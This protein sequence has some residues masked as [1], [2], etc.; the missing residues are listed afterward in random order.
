MVLLV[1]TPTE[2][3]DAWRAQFRR[4]DPSLEVRVW[5]DTGALDEIDVVFAW[6]TTPGDLTRY[7]NLRAVFSLGA[8][9]DGLLADPE[10][11]R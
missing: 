5:P 11:P 7:P 2:N 9:V 4:L 3:G 6:R 8:G 1:N 10:F